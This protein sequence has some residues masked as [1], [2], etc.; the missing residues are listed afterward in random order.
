MLLQLC[1]TLTDIF[2]MKFVVTALVA[3]LV[4][5]PSLAKMSPTERVFQRQKQY[6]LS[7]RTRT[8]SV[9]ALA[10]PKHQRRF[11]VTTDL[12]DPEDDDAPGSDELDLQVAFS[13]PRVYEQD[14]DHFPKPDTLDDEPLSDY[15]QIRLLVARAKALQAYSK[16]YSFQQI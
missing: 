8:K 16:K 13:R 14:R 3:I 15:V 10:L 6:E 4:S 7:T 9:L 2:M 1:W 11:L 5:M 12:T